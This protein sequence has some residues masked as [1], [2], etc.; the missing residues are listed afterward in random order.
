[1][2]YHAALDVNTAR[3]IVVSTPERFVHRVLI[4]RYY[5]QVYVVSHQA[6]SQYA[7]SVLGAS[8]PQQP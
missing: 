2:P 6:I 3:V 4:F 8:L 5:H 7:E 1:M